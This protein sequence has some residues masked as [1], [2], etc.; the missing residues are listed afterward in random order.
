MIHRARRLSEPAVLASM[1]AALPDTAPTF[2][3]NVFNHE[4]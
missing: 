2:Y 3:R 4:V 1:R